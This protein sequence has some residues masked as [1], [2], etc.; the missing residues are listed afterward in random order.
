MVTLYFVLF[1]EA[2]NEE[3][4]NCPNLDITLEM[5]RE[6]PDMIYTNQ[7]YYYWKLN[8]TLE[9]CYNDLHKDSKDKILTK[10]EQEFISKQQKDRESIFDD[11]EIL[12][13]R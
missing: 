6:D 5:T 4:G 1:S 8:T 10:E 13:F 2:R 7:Q 3:L 12:I 9:R 11:R